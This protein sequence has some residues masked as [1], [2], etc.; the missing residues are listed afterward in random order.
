MPDSES[1]RAINPVYI[2]VSIIGD[3]YVGKTSFRKRYLGQGFTT[4]YLATLGADFAIKHITTDSGTKFSLSIYDI[5]GQPRF[6]QIRKN[7]FIGTQIAFVMY[8]I[9]EQKTLENTINW[10][11]ELWEYNGKGKIPVLLL[12]NKVDLR[13]TGDDMLTMEDG[14]RIKNQ[15]EQEIDNSVPFY[16]TSAK[17]G[18]NVEEAFLAIL[19]EYITF[20]NLEDKVKL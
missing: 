4:E 5:A 20:Y 7:F 16:E 11:H 1:F 13:D 8:A 2:K 10:I 12:G 19:K 18:F 3:G 9:N 14:K 6:N 17:T 15:I